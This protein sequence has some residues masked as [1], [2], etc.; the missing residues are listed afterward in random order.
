[1]R[2]NGGVYVLQQSNRP[3]SDSGIKFGQNPVKEGLLT[4]LNL[5]TMLH[6]TYTFT[7]TL[8]VG[9]F[10]SALSQRGFEEANFRFIRNTKTRQFMA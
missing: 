3:G 2:R 5:F 7:L 6:A 4:H 1:M 9:F 8:I 10:S